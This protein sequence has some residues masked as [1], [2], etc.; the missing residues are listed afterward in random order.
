MITAHH[1]S[2]SHSHVVLWLLEELG[3]EYKIVHHTREKTGRSPDS[4]RA[5]HPLGKAPT[6]EDQGIPMVESTG[7]LLYILETYGQGKLRPAPGTPEAMQFYQW[8]TY[9]DGSA[10]AQVR[11]IWQGAG[12]GSAPAGERF[13]TPLRFLNN[14][15]EGQDYLVKGMF[16][17]ADIQLTFLEEG[18][19]VGDRIARYPNLKAHLARMRAR[20]GYKRAEAKGGPVAVAELFRSIGRG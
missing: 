7:I 11:A 17:A 20:D 18:I 4:L 13:L 19:E 8:M 16:T 12:A 10:A 15:L 5:V 9:V 2:Q 3:V 14:S 1:L 6:I